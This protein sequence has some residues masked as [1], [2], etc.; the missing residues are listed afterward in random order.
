M[1]VGAIE[2]EIVQRT[3]STIPPLP[4][5]APTVLPAG[6]PTHETITIFI[7]DPLQIQSGRV[8]YIVSYGYTSTNVLL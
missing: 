4:T 8:M 5:T 2:D 6:D 3:N 7:P 1:L